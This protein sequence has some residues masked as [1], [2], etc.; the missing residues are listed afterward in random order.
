MVTAQAVALLLVAGAVFRLSGGRQ[1]ASAS[2]VV[3]V[4]AAPLC[5]ALSHY[6]LVEMMQMTAVA[7]FIFLMALVPSADRLWIAS[8]LILATCFAMLAKVSSPA[9]LFRAGAGR[10][11]M[12]PIRG[13]SSRPPA[14]AARSPA[15]P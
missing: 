1:S 7:W 5:I 4:G 9:V 11:L 3:I 12:D 10:F 15:W 14:G 2:A 13:G 6:Y 8:Q